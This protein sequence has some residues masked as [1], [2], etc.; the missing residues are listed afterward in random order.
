MR[1]SY[2]V[3]T[4]VIVCTVLSLNGCGNKD[5]GD[6]DDLLKAAATNDAARAEELLRS[7]IDPDYRD[8]LTGGSALHLA[9]ANGAHDALRALLRHHANVGIVDD[10]GYTALWMAA[11][12]DDAVAVTMLL[13]AGADPD[14]R[15]KNGRSALAV[16]KKGSQVAVIL[17]GRGALDSDL[18]LQMDDAVRS[19]DVAALRDLIGRGGNTRWQDRNGDTLLHVAVAAGQRPVADVLITNKAD[20]SMRNK[21]GETP[22][23]MARRIGRNDLADH[24]SKKSSTSEPQ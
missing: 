15:A 20:L 22:E 6:G 8:R 23:M 2:M 1:R 5:T 14:V 13:E 18:Y 4:Y 24:L 11:S 7:G 12:A 10:N 19:G 3:V 9:A 21:A 16:A 17:R